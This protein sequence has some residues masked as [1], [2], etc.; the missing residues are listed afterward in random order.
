MLSPTETYCNPDRPF[1]NESCTM[2][3]YVQDA[4]VRWMRDNGYETKDRGL[5]ND[6]EVNGDPANPHSYILGANDNFRP[7]LMPGVIVEALFL[8]NSE[9]L[10]FL[11]RPDGFDIVAS[12]ITEGIDS[13]FE[14]LN[15]PR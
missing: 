1:G 12:A 5:K 13:Y 10:E 15:Q 4:L 6:S 3:Y 11:R 14:W 8:S 2:A 9:D 7:S